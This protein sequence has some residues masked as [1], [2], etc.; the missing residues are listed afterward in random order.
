MSVSEA[1][2]EEE[3]EGEGEL[4]RA[5]LVVSGISLTILVWSRSLAGREVPGLEECM[6]LDSWSGCLLIMGEVDL[7][8]ELDLDLPLFDSRELERAWDAFGECP[9]GEPGSD[10]GGGEGLC[11]RQH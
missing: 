4:G 8:G 1:D 11:K 7:P 6:G 3:E 2:E 10:N 5:R 9:M